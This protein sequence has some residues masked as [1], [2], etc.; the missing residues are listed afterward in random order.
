LEALYIVAA[1]RSLAAPD[2]EE[3]YWNIDGTE[4]NFGPQ[5]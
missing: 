2:D 5:G 4:A 3:G 1:F